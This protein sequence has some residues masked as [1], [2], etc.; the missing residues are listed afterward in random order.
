MDI[1]ELSCDYCESVLRESDDAC[2]NCGAA[3]TAATNTY[4]QRLHGN[5]EGFV[6]AIAQNQRNY[7]LTKLHL[8]V[9]CFAF[10]ALFGLI[11]V[12]FNY[13]SVG[14]SQPQSLVEVSNDI[15]SEFAN[16][17]LVEQYRAPANQYKVP[18]DQ[19]D[20]L[21][22]QWEFSSVLASLSP[23]RIEMQWFYQSNGEWPQS[24]K[25]MNI[26]VQEINFAKNIKSIQFSSD[27]QMIVELNESFDPGSSLRLKAAAVM[28]NNYIEW[29]CAT[30]IVLY[31]PE[32]SGCEYDATLEIAELR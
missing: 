31:Q 3:R 21:R 20:S 22:T 11:W 8:A 12:K 14:D 23:L 13:V 1:D 28:M 19:Y 29:E 17:E 30:N 10:V 4:I 6:D 2:R 9:S 27:G 18:T 15:S 25:D 16:Q 26:D 5:F 24:F 32:I 7:R